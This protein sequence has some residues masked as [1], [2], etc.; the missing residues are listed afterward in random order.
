VGEDK[1]GASA[2][3]FVHLPRGVIHTYKNVGATSARFLT[4][5]VPA[6]LEKFFEEVGKPGTD[7]S[8]PPPFGEEDVEKLLAVAP[9]YGAEIPPPPEQ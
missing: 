4:L 7:L 9:N 3:S 8:T 5:M 2:G 6:G 1:I